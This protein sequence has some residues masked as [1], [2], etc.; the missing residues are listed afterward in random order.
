MV[1]YHPN[2]CPAPAPWLRDGGAAVPR[3]REPRQSRRPE[4]RACGLCLSPKAGLP[5]SGGSCDS[6]GRLHKREGGHRGER[7]IK[8]RGAMQEGTPGQEGTRV[9]LHPRLPWGPA[10]SQVPA[11]RGRKPSA[12]DPSLPSPPLCRVSGPSRPRGPPRARATPLGFPKPA[13]EKHPTG[14]GPKTRRGRLRDG[15][16]AR[17]GLRGTESPLTSARAAQA[18][19][20]G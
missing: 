15:I 12:R 20:E 9:T 10:R 19:R 18:R 8:T 6:R 11:L 16:G 3:T 1:K 17:G 13:S 2:T 7:I 5:R 14:T 4:P